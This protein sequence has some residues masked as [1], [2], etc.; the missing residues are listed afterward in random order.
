[1]ATE[2]KTQAKL[3]SLEDIERIE[4]TFHQDGDEMDTCN[5]AIDNASSLIASLKKAYS[6]LSRHR[7]ICPFCKA[8]KDLSG[9]RHNSACPLS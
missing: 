2:N 8:D 4:H 9:G 5:W 7:G 3:L 1:M 6:L